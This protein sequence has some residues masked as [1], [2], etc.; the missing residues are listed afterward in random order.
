MKSTILVLTLFFCS[1]TTIAQKQTSDKA[2]IAIL[3]T[4][5]SG[6]SLTDCQKARPNGILDEQEYAINLNEKIKKNGIDNIVYHFVKIGS[7]KYLDEIIIEFDSENNVNKTSKKLLG[8]TNYNTYDSMW[9]A[10]WIVYNGKNDYPT[11]AWKFQKKLVF[12]SDIPNNGMHYMFDLDYQNKNYDLR[13]NKKGSKLPVTFT[14]EAYKEEFFNVLGNGYDFTTP[15]DSIYRKS[16]YTITENQK[17]QM[18]E[19]NSPLLIDPNQNGLEKITVF[20]DSNKENRFD[21]INL[22]Y[23]NT[24]ML[25]DM[26]SDFTKLKHPRVP[27]CWVLAIIGEDENAKYQLILCTLSGSELKV[28]TNFPDSKLANHEGF[29][30]GNNEVDK[31]LFPE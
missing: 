26:M 7:N 9:D 22:E 29:Q 10:F 5:K 6:M 13:I 25:Q 1:L 2:V 17:S 15:V 28:F 4:I 19:G 31:I 8:D 23:E 11:L 27:N 30:I 21:E 18:T 12:M 16:P 14:K 24:E 3:N 20:F